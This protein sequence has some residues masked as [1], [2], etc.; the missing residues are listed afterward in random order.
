MKFSERIGAKKPKFI[1]IEGIDRELKN[2]I[3][4]IMNDQFLTRLRGLASYK[5]YKQFSYDFQDTILKIEAKHLSETQLTDLIKNSLFDKQWWVAYDILE[6]ILDQIK[7]FQIIDGELFKSKVN[8]VLEEE[9]AGYRIIND[10]LVPIS[11][12]VEINEIENTI[13]V[14]GKYSGLKGANFHLSQSLLLMSRKADP[15]YRNSIKESIT[16]VESTCRI[17]TNESTLGKAIKKLES[18]GVSINK[19]LEKGLEK[20]YSYTNN[21]TD[22]IRHAII[23][24]VGEPDFEDAKF[25]LVSC[26]AFINYL[27]GK[28]NKAGISFNN[29]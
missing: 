24:Q 27:I 29:E 3:W 18:K 20:L 22:G 14:T 9:N 15:D 19:E 11:N 13:E 16:A 6:F 5:R 21:K 17:L 26:S 4:N 8:K 28:A 1:Q 12:E 23:D 10:L 25:M 2:R 7:N